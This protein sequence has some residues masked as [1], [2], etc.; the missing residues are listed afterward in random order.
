MA[1]RDVVA[2]VPAD[3]ERA[4]AA[5]AV[6]VEVEEQDAVAVAGEQ[7]GVV[8]DAEPVAARAVDQRDGRA[9]A[10]RHVPAAQLH[11]A[12]G[13]ER[14][15]PL[16]RAEVDVVN[17]AADGQVGEV[18]GVADRHAR[19]ERRT[20]PRR[21]A[22][23]VHPSGARCTRRRTAAPAR[24]RPRARRRRRSRRACAATHSTAPAA[25]RALVDQLPAGDAR[26]REDRVAAS[27]MRA[28]L[29]HASTVPAAG[30]PP[31]WGL[32][33]SPRCGAPH[34]EEGLLPRSSA[35]ISSKTAT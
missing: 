18:D 33:A 35:A 11:A 1:R 32:L 27:A 22:R 20:R 15:R 10:R 14:D 29:G 25:R 31:P 12:R 4:P 9:V 8:G 7:A 13:R 26:H 30:A 16:G 6:A 28:V 5:L 24:A 21:R 34:R 23:R 3:A 19:R 17:G 2:G